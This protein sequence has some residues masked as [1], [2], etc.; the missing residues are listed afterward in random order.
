MLKYSQFSY[1]TKLSL[2]VVL[3]L[4]LLVKLGFWQL[5]RYQEKLELEQT[6]TAR[7]TMPAISL[8][9]V[10]QY[11]DSMYLPVSVR[12]RFLSDQAFFLDNQIHEGR[13][14]YDLIMPFM[15]DEGQ[16]LLINR[17]WMPA[18]GRELLPEIQTPA[19]DLQLTGKLYRLLGT[20]FTLGEDIWRDEWPK[21]IQAINFDRMSEALGSIVPH[22]IL[23]LGGNQPGA[24]LIRPLTMKTTSQKHLGYA[25]QWF[26]MALVLLGLYLWQMRSAGL[27]E[28]PVL[29]QKPDLSQQKQHE[30][31]S[32]TGR[33]DK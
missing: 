7:Q 20:P 27:K 2:L 12:G 16:Q 13:A 19:E 31:V 3:L 6:L 32:A 21:R 8:S 25:I 24:Y 10:S 26:L 33:G 23:R 17:G 11:A 28:Q 15:T 22:Y 9:D 30:P 18:Q 1:R 14:G 29:G 5:S 4:P